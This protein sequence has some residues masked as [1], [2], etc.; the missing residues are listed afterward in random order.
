MRRA[1]LRHAE[2]PAAAAGG[3]T[4]RHLQGWTSTSVRH[5]LHCWV[6]PSRRFAELA[7]VTYGLW[8]SGQDE[9]MRLRRSSLTS[10][11]PRALLSRPRTSLAALSPAH[12]HESRRP[13]GMEHNHTTGRSHLRSANAC[14]LSVPRT[15]TDN[16]R[17]QE[18]CCQWTSRVEQFTCGTV[19][20]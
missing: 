13:R 3:D 8:M 7:H 6:P 11:I 19:I 9:K 15:R 1:D 4:T 5:T 20:E 18:F 10:I 2:D 16:L 14:V 12:S 17:R